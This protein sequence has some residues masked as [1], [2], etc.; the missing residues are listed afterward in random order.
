MSRVL[1]LYGPGDLRYEDHEIP[2]LGPGDVRVRTRLGAIS[3]GTEGAW[4]FGTDPQL[5]PG[6]KPGRIDRPQ[7]PMLLGYEKLA[8]VSAVGSQVA[9]LT[10]GQR[11]VGHYGHAEEFVLHEGRLIP[12]PE[13]VTDVEAVAYSLSTVALHGIRRSRLRIGDDVL[14]TGVGFIGL[15]AVKLCR[16]AGANH[17]VVT[18]PVEK[19]RKLALESG[20]DEALDPAACDVGATLRDRYGPDLFDV[21]LETSSSFEALHDAMASLRRN[22]RVC[23]LSQLKGDYPSHPLF[24]LEFHLEELELITADGRGDVRKLARWYFH[25]IRRG[26]VTGIHELITHQVSFSEIEKGFEL[27]EGEPESVVKILVTYP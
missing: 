27:L 24:G 23:V 15:M 5:D 18:D 14:I 3:A 7:F 25:A 9:S 2:E 10:V 6:F 17:I 21:A 1:K 16:L 8:E 20:A 19:R 13:G 11:V 4:Y 26:A 12:V 22:G